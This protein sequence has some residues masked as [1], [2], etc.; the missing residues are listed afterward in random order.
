MAMAAVG[1]PLARIERR[2]PSLPMDEA[3]FLSE[4]LDVDGDEAA[5]LL[6]CAYTP[7]DEYLPKVVGSY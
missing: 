1:T 5:S 4:G 6:G 7:M 3:R 2:R